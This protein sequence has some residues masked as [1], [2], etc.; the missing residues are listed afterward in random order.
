MRN[1][2]K[3]IKIIHSSFFLKMKPMLKSFYILRENL[4]QF[5]NLDYKNVEPNFIEI[6]YSVK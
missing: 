5:H 6:S 1:T 2:K 3:T 4:I